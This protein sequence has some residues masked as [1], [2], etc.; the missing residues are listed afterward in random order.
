MKYA[1]FLGVNVG[2]GPHVSIWIS[3]PIDV[4]RRALFG[5]GL[6]GDFPIKHG[7]HRGVGGYGSTGLVIPVA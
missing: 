6:C 5:Y 3:S 2:K 7:M 4:A 1:S